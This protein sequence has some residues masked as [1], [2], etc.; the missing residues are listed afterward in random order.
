MLTAFTKIPE[1]SIHLEMHQLCSTPMALLQT[2]A[3]TAWWEEAGKQW[4]LKENLGAA[5]AGQGGA[6]QDKGQCR[7]EGAQR[8]AQFCCSTLL[9]ALADPKVSQAL[10]AFKH[11]DAEELA[12]SPVPGKNCTRA[13]EEEQEEGDCP[14]LTSAEDDALIGDLVLGLKAGAV[15]ALVP[16]LVLALVDGNLDALDGRGGDVGVPHAHLQ[17]PP[18][19]PR[20]GQAHCV[21]IQHRL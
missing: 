6:A 3:Y 9:L 20:Q 21:G 16:E 11:G 5:E 8:R 2:P 10:S 14:A 12:W 18:C 1:H 13:H 17:L 4:G 7:C 15:P 19:Q